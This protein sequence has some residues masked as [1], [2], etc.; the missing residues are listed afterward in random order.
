MLIIN[1]VSHLLWQQIPQHVACSW[2]ANVH[3]KLLQPAELDS[4]HS[5]PA[6]PMLCGLPC[7]DKGLEGSSPLPAE[8]P[9]I[10]MPSAQR[11]NAVHE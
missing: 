10:Q 4:G 2:T 5:T 11:G 1:N 9:D 3:S 7:R 8:H 6:E